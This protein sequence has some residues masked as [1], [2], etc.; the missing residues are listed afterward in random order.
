MGLSSYICTYNEIS[1]T[2]YKIQQELE[3]VEIH[4]QGS[5]ENLKLEHKRIGINCDSTILTNF[6]AEIAKN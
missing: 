2:I 5:S 4:N 6:E 1:I 3:F